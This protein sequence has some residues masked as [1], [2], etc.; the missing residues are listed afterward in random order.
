VSSTE[1][2]T[3]YLLKESV[4]KAED[5]LKPDVANYTAHDVSAGETSGVLYVLQFDA[6]EPDWVRLLRPVTQPPVD[7]LS[8]ST[9]ALLV[10][11]A[12]ERWF[13]LSF[14]HGR[15]LLDP[16]VY[17]RRFGLRVA[18]NTADPS[19]LRGAQAR[20]FNDYVL[21][22]SR[23][24][25]R[26]SGV[27]AL[28]LDLERD[29]V[30]SVSGEML[31][32]TFGKRI[33]GC[34]AVSLTAELDVS[35]FAAVCAR[36]LGESK[37]EAYKNTYPWIDRVEELTDTQTIESLEA[38]AAT[39]LGEQRFSEFDLFPPE[40]VSGEI[41]KFRLYPRNGGL[42]VI[43]PDSGLLRYPIPSAMDHVTAK[44]ALERYKLV[45]VDANDED[46]K[47][48]SFWECLH[49]ESQQASHTVVLDGGRWY[50]VEQD[51]AD[52]VERFIGKLTASGLELPIADR[53]N[54][55]GE[56]NERAASSKGMAL[57][58]KQLIRL[59][60]Q[61]PIEPCD[62]LSKE[63][64]FVH[65]KRRK[66]SGPLSHLFGQ[67]LVSAECLVREKEFRDKLREKLS[68]GFAALI[69]EPA[70]AA[71]HPIVLAL[72]T[73]STVAGSPA[74]QLPFFSKVFLR[75]IVRRLNSMSFKVYVDEIPTKFP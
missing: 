11:S 26:L 22:T 71:D 38:S 42:I 67:A 50:R 16:Q 45:G 62:L 55:E 34:D 57:L 5:A 27:E 10:L 46:I 61:S 31:D 4:T 39:T 41:V 7:K 53:D 30:T 19:K 74:A 40:L 23:Q 1:T 73:K 59:S 25:S 63:G 64:H 37:R 48:W 18:L 75:Q 6:K 36:L 32:S 3:V 2:I 14:G 21:H 69:H 43:E 17:V 15:H 52:D 44:E 65:V 12:A 60:G 9:G 68:P 54:R 47:R 28:E 66:G 29:L 49:Y 35:A 20:S 13:A 56:Y 33:E 58:D 70:A 24:V 8:Q 51:L 72:I